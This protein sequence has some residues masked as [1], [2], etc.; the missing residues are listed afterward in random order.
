MKT[1]ELS[2]ILVVGVIFFF[3]PTTSSAQ[4]DT[5]LSQYENFKKQAKAEYGRR[6]EAERD[7]H[8]AIY[9]IP[10]LMKHS[11]THSSKE[12]KY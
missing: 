1:K 10:L 5:F 8:Q 2:S 4:T 7:Q 11:A 12:Q 6:A 3:A 9:D